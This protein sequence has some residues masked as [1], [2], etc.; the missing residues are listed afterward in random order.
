MF[1]YS[2]TIC[3]NIRLHCQLWTEPRQSVPGSWGTS[4]RWAPRRLLLTRCAWLQNWG[5]QTLKEVTAVWEMRMAKSEERGWGHRGE[6][7]WSVGRDKGREGVERGRESSLK[8]IFAYCT[9]FHS[10]SIRNS[11]MV[12]WINKLFHVHATEYY[13]A[14]KKK[15]NLNTCHD[16]DEPWG[17]HVKWNVS[18]RRTSTVWCHFYEVPGVVNL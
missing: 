11:R 1:S 13:P 4:T 18:P 8:E 17:H 12:E 5:P 10:G 7:S 14:L 15:G 9:C 3:Q 2:I 16:M 6:D